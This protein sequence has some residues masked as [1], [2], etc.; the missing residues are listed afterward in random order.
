M[1][2]ATAQDYINE[3][4]QVAQ[5][6]KNAYSA[7]PGILP[8]SDSWIN[9]AMDYAKSKWEFDQNKEMWNLQNEYNSPAAQMQRLKEAGLSPALMYQQGNP[10]NSSNVPSFSISQGGMHPRGDVLQQTQGVMSLVN[11]LVENI[12]NLYNQSYDLQLKRNAVL[13][14]NYETAQNMRLPGYGRGIYANTVISPEGNMQNGVFEEI[15]PFSDRFDP[16]MFM[17]LQRQG[18]LPSV[19]W[20]LWQNVPARDYSKYRADYQHWYNENLLPLFKQYQEGKIDLQG[21]EKEYEEYQKAARE[22]IP[23][24]LR[25]ILEP[26]LQWIS[27]FIKFIVKRS[28]G[29]FNHTVK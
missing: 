25:G 10:G 13:Q 12:T 26:I 22:M 29:N 9:F 6:G 27:P 19:L 1:P 20:Q 18:K 4:F 11:N 24:E 14:S 17:A 28:S 7:T 15:N 5:A 2:G 21:Y 16:S 23:P 3:G 8:W